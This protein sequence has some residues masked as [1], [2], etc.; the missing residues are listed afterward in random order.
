M[1]TK[2]TIHKGFLILLGMV[3]VTIYSC[4]KD[5]NPNNGSGASKPSL[6][7]SSLWTFQKFEYQKPDGSWIPDPDAV[8][9][10]KFTILFST[11]NTTFEHDL[12]NGYTTSGTW[13]FSSNSTVLTITAGY[14]LDATSYNLI[15]LNASTLQLTY[16]NYPSGGVYTNERIT[17]IH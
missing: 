17:F 1:A 16:V 2:R 9:A 7:T 8:D 11:N 10:N 6:L 3:M 4:K 5:S 15:Q 14:D 13:A 12:V